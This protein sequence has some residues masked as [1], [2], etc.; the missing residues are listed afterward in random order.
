MDDHDPKLTHP[1]AEQLARA[2]MQQ[3]GIAA[4]GWTFQ[5]SHGKRRMGETRIQQTRDP[6][7]GK[8]VKH[9]LIRL[10]KHL[11][12]M[13][14]QSIVR[15]VI[16]H[17]IAHAFAGIQN[18]HNQVWKAACIKVGAK[19]QRLADE[20]VEV[21]QSRYAIVCN[22]CQ[23][24][25]AQRHRQSSPKSLANAYCKH[26]GKESQGKLKL[27]DRQSTADY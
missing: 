11:V 10:S 5:W 21:V 24:E 9:K 17:E 26:C 7:T 14:P 1:Q 12:A 18:G 13:N 8:V 20:T 19:P 27:L 6:R 16:L 25:L 23:S 15:D 22:L 2:L 4:K 3:H